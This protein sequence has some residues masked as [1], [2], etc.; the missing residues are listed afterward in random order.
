VESTT[1]WSTSRT[2][3]GVTEY[4]VTRYRWD[5]VWDMVTAIVPPEKDSTVIAYDAVT[6][7][8]L[9]QHDANG[10][11]GKVEF[12]YVPSTGLVETVKGPLH[13]SSSSRMTR[14]S[15]TSIRRFP[16]QARCPRSSRTPSAASRVR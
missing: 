2:V 4:A 12:T 3:N 9:Y 10:P 7:N 14:C 5:P 8:R 11:A 16:R 1:D 13:R 6:G 15:R